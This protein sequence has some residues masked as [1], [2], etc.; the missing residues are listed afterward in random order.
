MMKF[1]TKDVIVYGSRSSRHY[2]VGTPNDHIEIIGDEVTTCW[3]QNANLN[4]APDITKVCNYIKNEYDVDISSI[5][6]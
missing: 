5:I 6:E 1:E 2:V 4:S 3:S